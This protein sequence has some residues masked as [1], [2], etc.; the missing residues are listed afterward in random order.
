VVNTSAVKG[1]DAFSFW[2]LGLSRQI[3]AHENA[4]SR[5]ELLA[6]ACVPRRKSVTPEIDSG[7]PIA[8]GSFDGQEGRA[9]RSIIRRALCTG[10]ILAT[11]SLAGCATDQLATGS[12]A[13]HHKRVAKDDAVTSKDDDRWKWC[14]QRHLD[15]QA[16]KAPAGAKDL[17]KKQED[18]R[19]CAAVYQRG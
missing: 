13:K 10:L 19:I 7:R 1:L 6:S 3:D 2:G 4:A 18:D 16:G 14:E 11:A 17:A 5:R 12:V 9:M 15:H 8:A